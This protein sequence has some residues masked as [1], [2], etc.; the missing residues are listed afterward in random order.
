VAEFVRAEVAPP[1]PLMSSH[2]VNR[3]DFAL[4]AV[5]PLSGLSRTFQFESKRRD[6]PYQAGDS[7]A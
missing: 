5:C 3:A 4:F 6:R 1:A 7:F 2:R